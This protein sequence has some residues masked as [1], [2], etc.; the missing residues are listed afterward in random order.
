MIEGVSGTGKT[1]VCNELLRRGYHALHGDRVLR[2]DQLPANTQAAPRGQSS[3]DPETAA[4]VHRL[5]IWDAVKV[6]AEINS[7]DAEVSFFCGGFR[8][9]A[10]LI[11]HFDGVFILEIDRQTLIQRLATRPSDEF[12]GTPAEKELILNLHQSK[13]DMP[14]TGIVI[15][16]KA[17]IG[18]VVDKIL[19][20]SVQAAPS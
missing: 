19:K 8:N 2:P 17:P 6:M 1:S 4:M 14:K 15:D 16:A 9:H 18:E 13:A 11:H 20:R 7:E 5:A 12:G 3:N 10:E